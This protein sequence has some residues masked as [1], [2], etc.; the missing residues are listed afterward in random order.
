MSI[1][2]TSFEKDLKQLIL[3]IQQYIQVEKEKHKFDSISKYRFFQEVVLFNSPPQAK[4]VEVQEIS[5]TNVYE[6]HSVQ[7]VLDVDDAVI[8]AIGFLFGCLRPQ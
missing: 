7:K 8:Q 6:E 5:K 3:S 2:S 1:Y 4:S